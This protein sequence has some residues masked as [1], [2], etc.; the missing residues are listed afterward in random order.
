M[1]FD[2]ENEVA[3]D[4]EYFIP[5]EMDRI[6]LLISQITDSFEGRPLITAP[7]LKLNVIN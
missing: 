3:N 5:D 2:L 1:N 6:S 4:I 7:H